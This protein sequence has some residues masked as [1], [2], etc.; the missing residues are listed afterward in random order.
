[1][2]AT[3]QKIAGLIVGCVCA[4][5]LTSHLQAQV[6]ASPPGTYYSAKDPDLVPYPFNPHPE[7]ETVEV[8]PGIFVYDDTGIPDTQQQ[9]I[10]R[11]IRRAAAEKAKM[12][13]S[14]P[15]LSAAA[16]AARQAAQEAAWEQNKQRFSDSLH[17]SIVVS[18]DT[19]ASYESWLA[20]RNELLAEGIPELQARDEANTRRVAEATGQTASPSAFSLEGERASV[21][22]SFEGDI[23]IYF[24]EHTFNAAKTI[25]T[26]K[27]WP[28]GGAGLSLLG[29]NTIV[30]MWDGGAARVSHQEFIPSGRVIQRD[31][32]TNLASHATAVTGVL[33][34]YGLDFGA[35]Y[36]RLVPGMAQAATVWA[37]D[38]DARLTEIPTEITNSLR[39]SNH[40][41]GPG[42]GWDFDTGLNIWVWYGWTPFSTNEDWKFGIYLSE[43]ASMD[44]F[45]YT[46]PEYLAVFSAGNDRTNAPTTQPTTHL[47]QDPGSGLFVTNT[48]TVRN[49]DGDQ[50]GYDTMN[51]WGSAKN[52]L[53][54]GAANDL[55]GGYT[56]AAGV[57]LASFSS[58]GPT[59]DGRIKP[60]VVANGVGVITPAAGAD[61]S[62]FYPVGLDGTSFSAPSVAGSVDLLA[63]RYR[64][65]HPNGR[66]LQAASLK[67]LV[68]QTADECGAALGPDYA[69]GWGLMNTRTAMDFLGQ[70]ATN[71]W[72]SY[73]K[74]VLLQ[75][76][77]II[78]FPIVVVG[79]TNTIKVTACWSDPAATPPTLSV[80]PTNRMLI[81]DLDLRVVGPSGSTNF[82]WV[83]NPDLVNKTAAAR[84]AAATKGD[85]VIDNV[86]QV[87]ITNAAAGSYTVRVTHKGTLQSD[88]AQWVSILTSGQSPQAKPALLITDIAV[89]ASNLITLKWSTVVGQR[90][91]VQY[92]DNLAGA[93]WTTIS[94]EVSAMRTNV[95]VP[96]SYSS[97]QP[98]RFYRVAEVE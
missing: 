26:D 62:Y 27:V 31:G 12:I 28:G 48:T 95:S 29:S 50:G 43:S 60:D 75:P 86:E 78:E 23:P 56:N 33:A 73:V 58:F 74:E 90:Y 15:V 88:Q 57:T 7:L 16:Q 93:G 97:A 61:D 13:A 76:G 66:R 47:V 85:N 5:G 32:S 81:N 46:Q 44:Q 37:H 19:P 89:T 70:N 67:G 55:V 72:K 91:Q 92:R 36:G 59:D 2:K 38:R 65:L 25:S 79:S 51:S 11:R 54:V 94:G 35:P 17:S 14:D 9:S 20:S 83:L 64:Q 71:G 45:T 84:G 30:G 49:S 10:S 96:L 1:M 82:P 34:G 42:S 41:Y 68:I 39:L 24:S 63:E 87:V 80:D 3:K 53:T 4:L 98:Q 21:L 6:Q 69:F 40:S 52:V 8:S 77:N 18:N 22:D